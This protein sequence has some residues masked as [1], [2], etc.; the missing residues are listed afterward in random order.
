[1]AGGLEDGGGGGRGDGGRSP[2]DGPLC[3][4][5]PCMVATDHGQ[6]SAFRTVVRDRFAVGNREPMHAG[7]DGASITRSPPGGAERA[8]RLWG[9]PRT[10][11]VPPRSRRAPIDE[12]SGR[13]RTQ[14]RPCKRLGWDTPAERLAEL[15]AADHLC[16]TDPS[17][18]SGRVAFCRPDG[19]E[20]RSPC[21]VA[22]LSTCP[23][24]VE[25][26]PGVLQIV[27]GRG[28][29]YP[30]VEG[31]GS[32]S[33]GRAAGSASPHAGRRRARRWRRGHRRVAEGA[34]SSASPG[35]RREP[36]RWPRSGPDRRLFGGAGGGSGAGRTPRNRSGSRH[37]VIRPV[38]RPGRPR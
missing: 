2:A 4:T 35:F 17:D 14:L 21:Q 38:R 25:D 22:T 19:R 16:C 28:V 13:R 33:S 36:R 3:R 29:V 15:P 9:G 7:V 20:R 12:G 18:S 27:G 6:M 26:T 34:R 10:P 24:P 31:P 32:A 30:G 5:G 11:V 23:H 1:M 37:R 8:H